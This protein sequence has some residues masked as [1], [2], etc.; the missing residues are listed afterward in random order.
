MFRVQTPMTTHVQQTLPFP[1]QGGCQCSLQPLIQPWICAPGTHYGCMGQGSVEYEVCPTLLHMASSGNWT[2]DL[3]LSPTPYPLGHVFSP[4]DSTFHVTKTPA[5]TTRHQWHIYA[6]HLISLPQISLVLLNL[7]QHNCFRLSDILWVISVL[8]NR[9]GKTSLWYKHI[10]LPE[11][12]WVWP[13]MW[14]C[15]PW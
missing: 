7:R 1:W 14:S 11:Y 9:N 15:L 10:L 12:D 6:L 8:C 3:I 5:L 2:P 13:Q 4:R